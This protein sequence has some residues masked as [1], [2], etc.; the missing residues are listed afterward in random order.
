M[1][2]YYLNMISITI[3]VDVQ[4]SIARKQFTL[5]DIFLD[6]Q[7]AMLCVLLIEAG[8]RRNIYR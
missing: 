6:I 1:D 5:K 3:D 2:K 8:N 4:D 7:D